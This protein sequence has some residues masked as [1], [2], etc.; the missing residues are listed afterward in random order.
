MAG[1]LAIEKEIERDRTSLVGAM[2]VQL[3][4]KVDYLHQAMTQ[5]RAHEIALAKGKDG[6]AQ[7]RVQN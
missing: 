5:T 1:Q 3:A 7:E 6:C 2:R 4:H